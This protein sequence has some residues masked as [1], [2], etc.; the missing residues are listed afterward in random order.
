MSKRMSKTLATEIAERT[1]GVVNPQN[2]FIALAADLA[3]HGFARPV[4]TPELT[5]RAGL[6]AWLLETYAPRS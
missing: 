6:I 5:E 3:R 1:L 2:R 4:E